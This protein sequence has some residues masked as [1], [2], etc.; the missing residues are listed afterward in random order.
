MQLLK[1]RLLLHIKRCEDLLF[2]IMIINNLARSICLFA[3]LLLSFLLQ[4][5]LLFGF[6]NKENKDHLIPELF[7]S[8]YIQYK[9]VTGYE[10]EAGEFLS[11]TCR[12][13][14]L[15]VRILTDHIDSYNFAASLYPL[16]KGKPNIIFLNHI[17][18]VPASNLKAWKYPPY[19]GTITEDMVWGRGAI[20]NKGAAVMQLFA[21]ANYIEI[22]KIIDLPFNVTFLSVSNEETGGLLGASI[23]SEYFL[24]ELNPVVVYGEGGS[25]ITGAVK[26]NKDFPF[27]GISIAQKRGLWFSIEA[28]NMYSGHGSFPQKQ[29]P[30]RE[31]VMASNALIEAKPQVI[32]TDPVKDMIRKLGKY[33]RGRRKIVLRNIGFFAPL[34][35]KTLRDDPLLSAI[36]TNTVTLTNLYSTPGADNQVSNNAKAV[37]DCRL[38]PQTSTDVFI[39]YVKDKIKDYDVRLKIIHETPNAPVSEKGEFYTALEEAIRNSYDEEVGVAPLLFL[40][41]NDNAYFRMHG[42]PSYGLF[43]AILTQEL[44]G[45][46]HMAN[47][48]IPIHNLYEGIKI[49]GN[50]IRIIMDIEE[51]S[52]LF[53]K[54]L[55]VE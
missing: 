36:I 27:F 42:I 43:P 47:E 35:T 10:K 14:G 6:E 23:V 48:R 7:L 16:E 11:E 13:L 2:T 40:A 21:I 30:N 26:S 28:S 46:I 32:L 34:F 52:E 20:D 24:D 38:L 5:T 49:Y 54:K 18:V 22:S 37:F 45:T 8:E 44:M 41:N 39:E 31:I 12:D 53:Q 1:Y 55:T 17:D 19:S 15:H 25:G 33:E 3:I 50:L 9:S 29:Y 51:H 4:P